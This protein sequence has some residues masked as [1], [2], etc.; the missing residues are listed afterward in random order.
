LSAFLH[1]RCVRNLKLVE[2]LVPFGIER[3]IVGD[4]VLFGFGLQLLPTG[5]KTWFAI[6][7]LKSQPK[8]ITHL[9]ALKSTLTPV[10]GGLEADIGR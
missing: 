5:R 7:R 6:V 3:E 2:Q 1:L 4:T 10:R 9:V 8:R